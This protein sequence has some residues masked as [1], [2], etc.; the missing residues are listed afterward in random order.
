MSA[1][2]LAMQSSQTIARSEMLLSLARIRVGYCLDI[3]QDS[4]NL[5]HDLSVNS[6][7]DQ[8][9]LIAF[10]KSTLQCE[11]EVASRLSLSDLVIQVSCEHLCTDLD[12]YKSAFMDSHQFSLYDSLCL[13]IYTNAI[14]VYLHKEVIIDTANRLSAFSSSSPPPSAP[15]KKIKKQC[16]LLLIPRINY[17]VL[18]C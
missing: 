3:D 11:P 16:V 6:A 8:I 4:V 12:F 5:S 10:Q 15:S 2:E 14:Q 7:P 13:T 18:S 1:D 17:L 9:Q